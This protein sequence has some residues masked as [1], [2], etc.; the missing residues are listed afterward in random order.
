MPTDHPLNFVLA[1]E[2]QVNQNP[3]SSRANSL[4]KKGKSM[5]AIMQSRGK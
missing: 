1:V 3:C 5:Y 2:E 4:E